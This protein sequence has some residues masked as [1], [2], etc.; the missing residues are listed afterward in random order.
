MKCVSVFVDAVLKE[1]IYNIETDAQDRSAEQL[2]L[3]DVTLVTK[4]R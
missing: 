1:L 2:A 3:E 4:P